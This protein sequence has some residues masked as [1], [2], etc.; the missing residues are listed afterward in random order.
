[1]EPVGDETSAALWLLAPAGV[2]LVLS[3]R[4]ICQLLT[5]QEKAAGRSLTDGEIQSLLDCAE[6]HSALEERLAGVERNTK[7]ILDRLDRLTKA[8]RPG[9]AHDA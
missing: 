6:G 9:R 5:G 2:A 1:M 3:L 8:T 4:A 7:A